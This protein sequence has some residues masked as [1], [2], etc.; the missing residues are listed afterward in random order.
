MTINLNKLANMPGYGKAQ[1]ALRKAGLW[2]ILD[3]DQE[4]LDFLDTHYVTVEHEKS[5]EKII[6]GICGDYYSEGLRGFIDHAAREMA[7][8]AK[9]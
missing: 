8:E 2:R 6:D 7:M 1:T 9:Q 3:T 5:Q 4:M